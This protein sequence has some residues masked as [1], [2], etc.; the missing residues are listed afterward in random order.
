[1][2]ERRL[3]A[4][5]RVVRVVLAYGVVPNMLVG[6]IALYLG[7]TRPLFNLDYFAV[8]I[9]SAWLPPVLTRTAI[10]VALVFDL[11]QVAAPTYHFD[12]RKIIETTQD[13]FNLYPAFALPIIGCVIFGVTVIAWAM[14]GLSPKHRTNAVYG[15]LFCV[16]ALMADMTF[17]PNAI[18]GMDRLVTEVNIAGSPGLLFVGETRKTIFGQQPLELETVSSQATAP[19]FEA[20]SGDAPLSRH[21]MLVVVE[22]WGLYNDEATNALITEPLQRLAA[23]RDD[24]TIEIGSVEFS[25]STVNGELRELCA[26]RSNSIRLPNPEIPL[27]GC[28]PHLMAERGY[29]SIA[30]HGYRGSMFN[31]RNWY[32]LAGFDQ[33]L[34]DADLSARL[35]RTS[36]CGSTFPGVCD[37]DIPAL[38]GRTLD[39]SSHQPLLI[40]WLTLNAHLPVYATD[41]PRAAIE[42]AAAETTARDTQHCRLVKL[43]RLV[44][45]ALANLMLERHDLSLIVVGDHAPAFVSGERRSHLSTERVPFLRV[46]AR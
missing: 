19:V 21:V 8:A 44:M 6:A 25:G 26:L 42:C 35:E 7:A 10:G 37:G 27:T 5:S 13:L 1:M 34:F 15:L 28:L 9:L 16:S 17:S 45:Q 39:A 4:G 11:M 12:I 2:S 24:L 18:T 43:H 20:L 41:D 14:T 23:D 38:I 32:P 36:R 3:R 31:R 33:M 29:E 22:S 30:I 46:Q 40:Y